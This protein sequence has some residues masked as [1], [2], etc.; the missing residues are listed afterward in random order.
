MDKIIYLD[1]AVGSELILKG[2][3]LPPHIWSA[4]VNLTNPNLLLEIHRE[5]I[6]S[7]ADCITTNTF[8]T[9]P[10]AYRKT[11]LSRSEAKRMAKE[12]MGAAISIANSAAGNSVRVLG[13]IAPL[14]DC[15][16]PELFPG[17][18]VAKNEFSTIA[19]W[20]NESDVDGYIL[21]T[22]NNIL[23]TEICLE[24]IDSS[25]RPTWVSFNLL[26]S[27]RIQSGEKLEDAIS[28]LN[29]YNIECFL[30][31]CNSLE[32]TRQAL[33]ISSKRCQRWGIYPNLGMGE[34]SPDGV[35]T[36]YSP[37]REFISLCKAA[38]DLGASVVG[39]C[40]GT[41]PRHIKLLVEKLNL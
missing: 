34:P 26:D 31:N 16:C 21:E 20:F 14:E 2:E 8:R 12:S 39:G 24:A 32:R 22:M 6:E 33:E 40:C 41:S 17:S 38:V 23:E 29:N 7:G 15:Y 13:S 11:G 30:L 10:R 25:N 9:T 27:H 1:G 37:D 4:N 28:M 3:I 35:I 5:Y 18:S 19:R 36:E